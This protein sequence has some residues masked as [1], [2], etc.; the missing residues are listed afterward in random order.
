MFKILSL[1]AT[2]A[3]MSIGP[4]TSDARAVVA[5]AGL[6]PQV[7]GTHSQIADVDRPLQAPYEP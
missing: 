6:P 2:T 3:A 1:L 7:L 5:I 4:H